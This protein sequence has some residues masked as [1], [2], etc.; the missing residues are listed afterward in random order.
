MSTKFS[1]QQGYAAFSQS[2]SQVPGVIKYIVNQEVHHRKI[3][4]QEEYLK[5]LV[6]FEV[7]FDERY[8]FKPLE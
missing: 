2:R 4:F 8:I 3:S 1:W 5:M 6:D 7:D